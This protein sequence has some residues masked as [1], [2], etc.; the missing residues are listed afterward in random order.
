M[1]KAIEVDG[2]KGPTALALDRVAPSEADRPENARGDKPERGASRARES[3]KDENWWGWLGSILSGGVA[4]K[5]DAAR[6][7][8][9]TSSTA[10]SVAV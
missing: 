4:P 7:P 2:K 9:P 3:V 6:L 8:P 10:P 1:A 5:R